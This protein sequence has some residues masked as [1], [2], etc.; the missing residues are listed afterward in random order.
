MAP[1]V[2]D[3]CGRRSAASLQELITEGI[4]AMQIYF[5]GF[6]MMALQFVGQSTYVALNRPKQ[7]VFVS[8]FRKVIIV[9]PLTILLPLVGGLGT[10]GVFWAE[11]VSNVIGGM[12][13]FVTMMLTVWPTL[14]EASA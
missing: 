5:C 9:V 2:T 6:F 3:E 13:C 14:K 8:L 10:D 7:A 4:P 11:P 12:A 1:G